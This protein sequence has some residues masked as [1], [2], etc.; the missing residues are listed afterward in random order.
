MKSGALKITL[1]YIVVGTLWILFSGK[2]VSALVG[3]R[4]TLVMVEVL[5]GCFYILATGAL[6]HLLISRHLATLQRSD[7]KL[8]ENAE[9]FQAI[10]DNTPAVIYVR[11]SDGRYLLANRQ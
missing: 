5:K 1:V 10:L 9:R 4:D 8:R 7:E 3:D 2:L 11:A 6:V